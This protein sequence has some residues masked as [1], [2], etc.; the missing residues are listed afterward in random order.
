MGY[1]NDIRCILLSKTLY[2]KTTLFFYLCQ[3]KTYIF[4]IACRNKIK[5]IIKLTL[6]FINQIDL[7]HE[8]W[9]ACNQQFSSVVKLLIP[10]IDNPNFIIASYSPLEIVCKNGNEK[11]VDILLTSKNINIIYDANG[12]LVLACKFGHINIVKTLLNNPKLLHPNSYFYSIS[13]ASWNPLAISIVRSYND[14]INIL[15]DDPRIDVKANK[16]YAME[17]A[18]HNNKFDILKKLIEKLDPIHDKYLINKYL[19]YC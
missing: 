5:W 4:S 2:E 9:I 8:L 12:A 19:V 14:I 16:C 15:L 6:K 1:N 7:Q 18:I 11:I 10:Y 13:L 3:N 17:I